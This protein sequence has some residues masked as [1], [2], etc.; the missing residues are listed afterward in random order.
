MFVKAERKKAKLRLG[1]DGP[2]G[3]GKSMGALLIAKGIGGKV[4]AIDTEEGSLSLYS[5]LL[6]FDVSELRPPFTPESYVKRIHEAEAAGYDIII[7]DSASHEWMG[8]GGV[9]DIHDNMPGNS[10]TNWAKVNPRHNEFIEAILR[11]KCHIICT[12]RSKQKHEMVEVNGKK[13]VKKLGMGAQQREGVEYE[14]TTVLSLDSGRANGSKDRTKLFRDGDWFV[15]T[16]DTG[17]MILDWLN[18]GKDSPAPFAPDELAGILAGANSVDDLGA[19]YKSA[20]FQGRMKASD[21]AVVNA[22]V[23]ARKAA[24]VERENATKGNG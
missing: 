22:A 2:S 9:L 4:A 6:D 5:D 20:M 3:S 21:V 16:E 1:L 8:Q 15:I 24:L 10:Y 18:S 7:I 12:L 17:K 11:S 23:A 13:E 14:L 19:L